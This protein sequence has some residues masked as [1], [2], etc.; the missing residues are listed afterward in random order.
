MVEPISYR[1][2]RFL[3]DS[4]SDDVNTWSTVALSASGYLRRIARR[5]GIHARHYISRYRRR[6]IYLS[7]RENGKSEAVN[8]S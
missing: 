6:V 1:Y 7:S 5:K 8:I 3:V 4:P 2:R